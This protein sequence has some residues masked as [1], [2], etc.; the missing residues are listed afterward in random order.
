MPNGGKY[1]KCTRST[2][3]RLYTKK[4][5]HLI[6]RNF[7]QKEYDYIFTGNNT[8]VFKFDINLNFYWSVSASLMLGNQSYAAAS[9]GAQYNQAAQDQ[10]VQ[11]NVLNLKQ[12]LGTLKR[13]LDST[14]N[15]DQQAAL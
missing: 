15:A 10:L 13:G 11:Q 5:Q 8:E 9:V 3:S 12:Q 6:N 7:M 4:I 14:Q 2:R 1:K